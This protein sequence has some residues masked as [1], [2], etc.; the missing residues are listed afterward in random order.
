MD[1]HRHT[2]YGG[3]P[4]TTPYAVIIIKARREQHMDKRRDDDGFDGNDR[5]KGGFGIL[6]NA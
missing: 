6:S 5:D 2:I 1:K 3:F 4:L